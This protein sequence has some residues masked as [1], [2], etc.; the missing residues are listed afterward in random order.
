MLNSSRLA[1]LAAAAA[2]TA[3]LAACS[4]QPLYPCG[5]PTT[6]PSSSYPS[7]GYPTGQ[8]PS[9]ST[10][11]GYAEYGRVTNVQLVQGQE[12]GRTSGAGAVIGGIGGAVIGNQVGGGSGRD[13]ARIA[14]I[15]GG[16]IAGNAIEKNSNN[17][18]TEAYRV[19]VQTDNGTLRAYDLPGTTDLRAGDRVRIENG[20]L[21]RY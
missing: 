8:Y 7:T 10:A 15:V 11:P 9:G 17:R 3:T 21:F 1:S 4:S 19:S 2:L 13:V 14:G 6:Y 16:A 20:Q 18:V 5:Q 12:A